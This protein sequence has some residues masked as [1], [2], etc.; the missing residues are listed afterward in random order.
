MADWKT[1]INY[2][3]NPA[4]HAYAYGLVYQPGPEQN[5]GNPSSWA[6]AGVMDLSSSNAEVTPAYY[7][8]AARTREESPPGSPEQH[9]ANGHCQYQSSG[10]LYLG[11]TQ[12]GRMVL[13]GPHRAAY[14]EQT[15][16]SRRVG[17]DST[18]DS[19]AYISPGN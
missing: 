13:T 17:S 2:N 18:S 1:Q 4:Y 10:V 16:E 15:Q 12:T 6:E 3:Y 9:A 14:D 11:D 8:S 19:E 5:H 7:V